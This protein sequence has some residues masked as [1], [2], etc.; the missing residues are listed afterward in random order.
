M[1]I[2]IALVAAV[3]VAFITNF[4]VTG[5][6]P[7]AGATVFGHSVNHTVK[8]RPASEVL[9]Q[10]LAAAILAT[11]HAGL[12]EANAT[13][14]ALAHLVPA[15]LAKPAAATPVV[16]A[17][18][19]VAVTPPPPPVTDATSTNTANWQCIRVHESGDEYNSSAAPSGA[20]GI[21][22]VTWH[23]FGYSGWPYQAPASVQDALA[24]RLYNE[25]GWRPWSTRFV[26]GLG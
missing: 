15:A 14:S 5:L 8:A 20:Y 21:V 22:E 2:R 16:V 23:S 4:M 11:G 19:V 17:T 1:R 3:P 25:Y 7:Q 24:L 26:C 6:P 18:P 12:L 10:P 9:Q 13:S